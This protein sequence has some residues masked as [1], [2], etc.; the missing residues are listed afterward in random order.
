[1]TA[2]DVSVRPAAPAD[3]DA[4]TRVQARAWRADLAGVLDEAG[5]EG[6][7]VAGMRARWTASIEA[8][9]SRAHRVLVACEGT[10]VVGFATS[11]PDDA[12]PG[13]EVAALEVDPDHRRAGHASRLLA[14]C[15]DLAREDGAVSVRTWARAD[16]AR[17]SFL[18]AC[19][20]APDGATRTLGD[21]YVERRWTAAI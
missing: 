4:V 18:T 3:A 5:L 13:I 10:R 11:V 7:D 16:V 2:A 20:L 21:T 1:M 14:A 17:E 19:G 6:L 12:E 15:V 8:P 9:P